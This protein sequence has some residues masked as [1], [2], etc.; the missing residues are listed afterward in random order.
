MSIAI[1]LGASKLWNDQKC[2]QENN[3][4][5]PD[6]CSK[7][8][9]VRIALK[10]MTSDILTNQVHSVCVVCLHLPTVQNFCQSSVFLVF[11]ECMEKLNFMDQK[12]V[13]T[14]KFQNFLKNRLHPGGSPSAP[15]CRVITR[16]HLK[17]TNHEAYFSFWWFKQTYTKIKT[18]RKLSVSYLQTWVALPYLQVN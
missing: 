13:E 10:K 6:V 16:Y 2:V 15:V 7:C 1:I 18:R 12:N 14:T 4:D 5:H 17:P 11:L 8:G 3:I 9:Q